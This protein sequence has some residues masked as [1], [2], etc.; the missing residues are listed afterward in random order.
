V[1]SS[2]KSVPWIVRRIVINY[3]WRHV[4]V[5]A[6]VRAEA[7]VWL[8]FLGVILCAY[9][10]W[11]GAV[12]FAAAALQGWVALHLPRWKLAIDAERSVQAPGAP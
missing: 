5:V 10:Y 2:P 12:L 11:W 6:G 9:G 7:A 8:L 4:R 1:Q 3:E